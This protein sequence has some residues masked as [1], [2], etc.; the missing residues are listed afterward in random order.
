MTPMVAS[1]LIVVASLPMYAAMFHHFGYTGL[2][3]ASDLGI[4][5][6]TVVMAWLLNR[7]GLVP[8][9]GLP[10]SEVAKALATAVVAGA[11]CYAVSRRVVVASGGWTRDV[12]SLAVMGA[13]WLLV[14]AAGLWF[15]RSR[16]WRDLRRRDR[17]VPMAE[18]PAVLE[19]T[20]GGVQP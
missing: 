11:A 9:S 20:E 4:L 14:V 18:P 17:P 13:T 8:L 3:M 6:H 5:L 12:A 1:T 16:L 2:A 7:K 19:R 15:T 10:W